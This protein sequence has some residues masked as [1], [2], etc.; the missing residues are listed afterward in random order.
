LG[1]V[2]FLGVAEFC[3]FCPKKSGFDLY[4][5][6]F[7]DKQK[8][9][10]THQNPPPTPSPGKK[11]GKCSYFDNRFQEVGKNIEGC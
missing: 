8:M 4:R 10:L 11:K 7:D 6:F 1:E 9:A 5:W 2:I 3:N